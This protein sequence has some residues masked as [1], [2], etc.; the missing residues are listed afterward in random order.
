MRTIQF[1]L[2]VGFDFMAVIS[3]NTMG[4]GSELNKIM[5]ASSCVIV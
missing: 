3:S 2:I 1:N 5:I 4:S